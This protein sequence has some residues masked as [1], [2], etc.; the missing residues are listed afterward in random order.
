MTDPIEPP[1]DNFPTAL[2]KIRRL[3]SSALAHQ[4]KPA[5]LLIAIEAALSSALK[6][7]LPYT[8]TAYFASLQQCLE[9][10][11]ED[12]IPGAADEEL[13]ESE[14]M[15]QGALIPATLYLL[16]VVIP[17]TPPS[18][19]LSKLST[20]VECLLPLFQ[21]ALPHPPALRSLLQI[22]TSLLLLPTPAQ[23]N[24]TPQLKKAWNYLLELNLDPRPKV[25]HLAQE[26]VRK[27]LTT[28]IPPRVTAGGHPYLGRA[29]E[30]VVSV[31]EEEAKNGGGNGK[32]KKARFAGAEDEEAGKKAIWVVQGLRGW[33][34]VWGDD[35]SFILPYIRLEADSM[36]AIISVV[37]PFTLASPFTAPDASNILFTLSPSLSRTKLY[38]EH[39]H[40]VD[41]S[42]HHP[43]FPSILPA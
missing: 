32:A 20:L 39:L 4:S 22:T 11:V 42:P 15:G 25:R 17:E 12:E 10:A 28:P 27:V 8:P 33:V 3:R 9:K 16:G 35:V 1:P 41:E 24:S 23:L 7:P 31:L 2:T 19:V 43:R 38:S 30:W 40:T 13:A 37:F 6:T 36:V 34:S 14:N 29:R 18:V 5:T 21:T 26:G